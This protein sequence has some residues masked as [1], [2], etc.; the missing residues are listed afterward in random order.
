MVAYSDGS[1]VTLAIV[2]TDTHHANVYRC[3]RSGLEDLRLTIITIG[4][5]TI[6]FIRYDVMGGKGEL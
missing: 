5:F 4:E 6:D 2:I 1:S 3:V